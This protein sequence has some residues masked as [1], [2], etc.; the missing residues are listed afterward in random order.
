MRRGDAAKAIKSAKYKIAGSVSCGG[1]DH[2]YLEGQIALAVP[3]EDSDMLVYSSTQHPT[4]VQHG[5]ATVLG[6]PVNAVTT[7]TRR[8]GGGFGGKESQATIIAAL[9]A[10]AAAHTNRP[11]KLR[12]TRDDDMV[13]TGKRHD[14]LFRYEVG[15]DD[16]GRI[17]GIDLLMACRAGHVADL[18]SSVLIRALCHADNC[19]YLPNAHIHGYPCKTNTVSNTGFRGFGGP[20]G[21][22][23]IETVI[24]HIARDRGLDPDHVRR[25]NFY[26]TADRDT[27]HYGQVVEDNIIT[28]IVDRLEKEIDYP[29]RKVAVAAFNR[30]NS[31]LKKGIALMPIKFGI[32]FNLPTLNQAGALVHVYTDGSVHL[33]HGGTEMG[34]GLYVKVAQIV[35]STFEIDIDT[36]KISATNTG[37]VPNTSATA[38]SSGS[39]LNGMAAHR[40]PKQSCLCRK[41]GYSLFRTGKADL[42]KPGVSL[43]RRVLFNAQDRLGQRNHDR[44]TV[45]LLFLWR[46]SFRS[47]HRYTDR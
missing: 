10:L 43:R 37:K 16:D 33:N 6:I 22:V 17:E 42:A 35:A 30:E 20:Q 15:V 32:S 1:Q 3:Q 34:Q 38:A 46:G 41:P 13:V 5:V 26:D 9:A 39:D 19:Y 36:V 14:F 11:V 24:D 23:A 47:R 27:T 12:L 28:E 45:L 31:V 18:S 29:A 44:P 25:I 8:M 21:M 7:E 4:E 40:I 2:F